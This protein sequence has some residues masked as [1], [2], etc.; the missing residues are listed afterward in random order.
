MAWGQAGAWPGGR[1]AGCAWGAE[2]ALPS[3]A[4]AGD[5]V[6]SVR[7]EQRRC[8]YGAARP[9]PALQGGP[10][11]V[12]QQIRK[13]LRS[14]GNTRLVTKGLPVTQSRGKAG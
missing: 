1:R 13:P 9:A 3:E 6:P 14:S 10:S 8:A 2:V 11:P 7:G 4:R 5:P 12:P